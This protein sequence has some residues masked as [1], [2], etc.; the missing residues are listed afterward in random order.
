M[1]EVTKHYTN[2]EITV[3]WKSGLCQHSTNCWKG[4]L[5]VFDPRKSPWINMDGANSERIIEQVM[6]CPSGALSYFGNKEKPTN[7]EGDF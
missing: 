4:L 5:S 1:K 3:V 6:Q 2:G 7:S